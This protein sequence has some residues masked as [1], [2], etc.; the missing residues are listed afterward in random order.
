[1]EIAVFLSRAFAAM[2]AA[3]L[4]RRSFQRS[5]VCGLRRAGTD[6]LFVSI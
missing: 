1:M 2:D 6:F 5:K 4:G 3:G